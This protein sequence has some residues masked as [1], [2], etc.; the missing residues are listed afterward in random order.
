MLAKLNSFES[1]A[2][3][4]IADVLQ[5]IGSLKYSVGTGKL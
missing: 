4:I 5:V 2:S 1:Y 3:K